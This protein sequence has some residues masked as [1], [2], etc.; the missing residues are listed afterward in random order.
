MNSYIIYVSLFINLEILKMLLNF[1]LKK[2][3]D[4]FIVL[5][6]INIFIN[7]FNSHSSPFQEESMPL[8]K[9]SSS[10]RKRLR[11]PEPDMVLQVAST[12]QGDE[13]DRSVEPNAKRIKKEEILKDAFY[14]FNVGQ[15]NSQLATYAEGLEEPFGVL[16][17]CGSSAQTVSDKVLKFQASNKKKKSF[18]VKNDFGRQLQQPASTTTSME[19]TRDEKVLLKEEKLEELSNE[20][21]P[22]SQGS[23]SN[24]S[25]L[26]KRA[27]SVTTSIKTELEKLKNLFVILSHPDKDHINL[28]EESLPNHLN[29]L[30]ILCGNF[31]IE[32]DNEDIRTN[33][34]NLFSF[35]AKRKS[36]GETYVTLPYFW[37]SENISPYSAL[38]YKAV[39]EYVESYSSSK[40]LPQD[41]NRHISKAFQG[42]FSTF[43]ERMLKVNKQEQIEDKSKEGTSPFYEKFLGNPQL[44]NIYIWSINHISD[45]INNHSSV[46]SFRMPNLEKTFVCTGDAGPEVFQKI[47]KRV[48]KQ[49]LQQ[50]ASTL[51]ERM[52]ML[53]DAQLHNQGSASPN[54]VLLMLPHHGAKNNLSIP[55]LDLFMP[56]ILGISAGVGS[57]YNHPNTTLIEQY[58]KIYENTPRL[59]QKLVEFWKYYS[60]EID[61][62]YI[63]F[64]DKIVEDPTDRSKKVKL[65]KAQ[66]DNLWVGKLAILA[67][68]IAG[69]IYADKESFY[70]QYLS[71]FQ[72]GEESY[73]MKFK[74]AAFEHDS[75][76]KKLMEGEEIQRSTK[77]VNLSNS[78]QKIKYEGEDFIRKKKN[79]LDK[80][81]FLSFNGKQLLLP[82]DIE[83]GTDGKKIKKFYL[84]NRV[85]EGEST[86]EKK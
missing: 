57:M 20:S 43:L 35:I 77:K 80:G 60:K 53:I 30:F 54:I 40:I 36:R 59:A 79:F 46:I 26:E 51:Q 25:K 12:S 7:P 78:V 5:S 3:L 81:I 70:G 73:K 13:G 44:N 47:Q 1:S 11:D 68:G 50:T 82:L 18:L 69:T 63:T 39:R 48:S 31:F 19:G 28:L 83:H 2:I 76:M 4:S 56:H 17:D 34:G 86:D 72:Y 58:K 74:K 23:F 38:Q 14:I 10:S 85:R 64:N 21:L 71:Y 15:G 49:S 6:L 27:T 65:Q 66:L 37:P 29:I 24:E 33:V 32:S 75:S 55:M 52:R 9:A 84:G 16:Y 67:T 8:E 41:I 42:R 45:D 62:Y 61:H 22:S